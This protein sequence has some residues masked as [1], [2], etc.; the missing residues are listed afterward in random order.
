MRTTLPVTE[1]RRRKLV[2]AQGL[3]VEYYV[4]ISVRDR[5]KLDFALL[6]DRIH[7]SGNFATYRTISQDGIF[8]I[9]LIKKN[10]TFALF[11][12]EII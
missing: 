7:I 4:E 2:V 6:T 8:N 11:Q 1:E 10:P 5:P 12:M 9:V 3:S